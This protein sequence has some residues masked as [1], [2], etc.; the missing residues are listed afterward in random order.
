M[1]TPEHCSMHR[2][3]LSLCPDCGRITALRQQA[4]AV[5]DLLAA[6]REP[7]E[8]VVPE[9]YVERVMAMKSRLAAAQERIATLEQIANTHGAKG[10]QVNH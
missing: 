2:E 5:D 7:Y 1:E 3:Y 4:A 6:I 10:D 8:S 9:G